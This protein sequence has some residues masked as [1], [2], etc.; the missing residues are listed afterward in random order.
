MKKFLLL[1]AGVSA[2]MSADAIELPDANRVPRL[3][4]V[5]GEQHH[6]IGQP[7]LHPRQQAGEYQQTLQPAERHRQRHQKRVPR[8]IPPHCVPS[9]TA[10][11][12]Q[13]PAARRINYCACFADN[14]TARKKKLL[15]RRKND[16]AFLKICIQKNFEL[17]V[18]NI[19]TLL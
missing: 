19:N 2:Y 7:H 13:R 4:P 15:C 10:L 16:Y 5:Q 17:A 3:H 1:L 11:P 18:I 9:P 12:R 14:I 8:H 6:Q